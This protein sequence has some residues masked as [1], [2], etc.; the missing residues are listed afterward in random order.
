MK[1]RFALS[2]APILILALGTQARADTVPDKPGHHHQPSRLAANRQS[3]MRVATLNG[4]HN[5][6]VNFRHL[7][8]RHVDGRHLVQAARASSYGVAE[9]DGWN[10]AAA[11]ISPPGDGPVGASVHLASFEQ[12]LPA[13]QMVADEDA[14]R[15]RVSQTG[16]ASY[17][18]GRHNGRR[19]S[20]GA[21]FDEH[22]MTAAHATL[23]FGTKVLVRVKGTDRTVVVTITD[24]LFSRHRII[25]LSVGAAE[26]LGIVSD[27]LA[28]VMLTPED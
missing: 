12:P 22:A 28:M 21:I 10:A 3:R 7:A 8:V 20:S 25:D 24:L 23:P 1:S 13:G 2:I 26:Q 15:M 19:T 27:G 14:S 9:T 11:G 18:G 16:V 5:R 4:R 17:Y 6:H